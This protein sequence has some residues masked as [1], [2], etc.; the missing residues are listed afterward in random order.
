[1]KRE[2]EQAMKIMEGR[3]GCDTL[4]ALATTQGEIPFVRTVNSY[5]ENGAFYV[6]T[7]ALSDKMKQLGENPHAAVCGDWFTGHAL[8]ESLGWICLPENRVI[9]DKL[10]TVFAEWYD[11]GHIDEKDENT[12]ILKLC[13][14]DGVLADHGTWYQMDFTA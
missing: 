9:A 14:T 12:V 5:Y 3:F 13:L 7:H 2:M 4:I 8:G 6:I 11:N 10:R 1:M